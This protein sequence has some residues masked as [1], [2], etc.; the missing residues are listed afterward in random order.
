MSCT[1]VKQTL[2]QIHQPDRSLLGDSLESFLNNL[3]GPS[4]I[5]L[6]GKDSTRTRAVCTL[7]HGNEPS[8]IQAIY[9]YLDEGIV[10]AVNAVFI[11]GS[12]QAALTEPL[13]SHR[14]LAGVRD[15]NRCFKP[16]FNDEPGMTASAILDLLHTLKPEALVDLHN[17]SGSGPAFGVAIKGDADHRA[18][19]AIFTNDLIVTDLRLGAIM[20]FSERDVPT[21]TIECGGAGDASAAFVAQEGI[22]RYLS[23]DT[24]RAEEGMA[25][26]VNIF[27]N[28]I[29]LELKPGGRAA[30]DQSKQE[31]V[32]ITL[33]E[34]AER[35]NYGMVPHEEPLAFLG[36]QGLAMLTAK[37]HLGQERLGEFFEAHDGRLYSKH[38][39]KLFMVT[40]NADIAAS[41][42]LFYFISCNE[43]A[44]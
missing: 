22:L 37:D 26:P 44:C 18:L 42:C 15:L 9:R 14:M 2:K 36:E 23:A 10:P 21:V 16:P 39:I 41:D 34:N 32:D 31:H 13:F 30:Y 43:Q 24:I 7:L 4:V 5:F 28:P 3:A 20:E 27:H 19:T 40:T 12:I 25:Y 38:P 29:R 1:T 33:P 35:L 11:I 17:T 6:E 8:G